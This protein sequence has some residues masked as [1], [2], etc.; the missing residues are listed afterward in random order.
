MTR[1]E[2]LT[3]VELAMAASALSATTYGLICASYDPYAAVQWVPIV[4]IGAGTALALT[5]VTA[6]LFLGRAALE[7]G[8]LTARDWHEKRAIKA[9]RRERERRAALAAHG[10]HRAPLPPTLVFTAEEL[11]AAGGKRAGAVN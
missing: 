6:L 7:A 8:A 1:R 3:A 2:I 4:A 10:Q 5:A 11:A 9:V